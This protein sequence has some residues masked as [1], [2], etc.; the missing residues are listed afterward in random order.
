MSIG[1]G[2]GN[3]FV[4]LRNQGC[5]DRACETTRPVALGR[6][7]VS[8]YCA[9]LAIRSYARLACGEE[10]IADLSP[11]AHPSVYDSCLLSHA[12]PISDTRITGVGV[13]LVPYEV[14][15]LRLRAPFPALL[16]TSE[17]AA[18]RD[19]W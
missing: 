14:V 5:G 17:R 15:A 4:G 3:R 9:Q 7:L 2:R 1:W 10:N 13:P 8:L 11:P 18:P 16:T 19:P 6:T 12:P